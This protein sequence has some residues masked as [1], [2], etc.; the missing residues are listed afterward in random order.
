MDRGTFRHEVQLALANLRDVVQLRTMDLA[1]TLLPGLPRSARGWELSR[2]LLEAVDRLRPA[3]GD[4]DDWPRRRYEILTLRYVNGL[5]PDQAASRLACTRRHFYRQLQRALDEFSEFLWAELPDQTHQTGEPQPPASADKQMNHLELLRREAAP[6][7]QSRQNCQF[8]EVWQ[9]VLVVLS[10]LLSAR[11]IKLHADLPTGLPKVALSPQILKQFLLALLG[12]LIRDEQIRA[13][14][15]AAQAQSE[16][17]E[18]IIAAQKTAP[19]S[20]EGDGEPNATRDTVRD[21]ASAQLAAMHGARFAVVEADAGSTVYR[22]SLPTVGAQTVLVVEDNEEVGLL[23][24]RYL[25]SGGY[26]PLIAMSG[27]EAISLARSQ[28]LYAVTL[29]LM[30]SN[31]DGW[32]VLQTLRHDPQTSHLPIIVCTVLDHQELAVMLGATA[33]LKKPVMREQLLQTLADLRP[34]CPP[35]PAKP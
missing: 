24:Q 19:R 31:E 3:P 30:M 8:V 27:A 26:Q 18:L 16:G 15:L 17:L 23:F 34:A 25:A 21:R 4:Q 2:L 29:D 10:P 33:F 22:V 7:L 5:S 9:S 14:S 32:D 20:R 35:G 12:D 6:L 13:V 11:A 28:D 1:A